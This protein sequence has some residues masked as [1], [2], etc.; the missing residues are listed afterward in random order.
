MLFRQHVSTDLGYLQ[1]FQ[2]IPWSERLHEKLRSP[3]L[4]KKFP[5]FYGTPRF[6]TAF[7]T[8]RHWSLS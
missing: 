7:T 8:A 6:I 1:A 3:Q 5:T 4:L 2:L